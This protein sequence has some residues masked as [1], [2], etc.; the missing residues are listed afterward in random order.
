MKTNH[1]LYTF[2][3]LLVFSMKNNAQT[4]YEYDGAGNRTHGDIY[5]GPAQRMMPPIISKKTERDRPSP[6]V[7]A[8][9]IIA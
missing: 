2:L 6:D 8:M 7:M 1:L 9:C 5:I 4:A 3:F